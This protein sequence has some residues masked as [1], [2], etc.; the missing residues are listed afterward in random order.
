L[1]VIYKKRVEIINSINDILKTL[2]F[3]S[4]N[5]RKKNGVRNFIKGIIETI[6]PISSE[7]YPIS[8]STFGKKIIYTPI[9]AK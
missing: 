6:E 2:S 1:S 3:N 4:I 8:D 7:L 9:D 5:F